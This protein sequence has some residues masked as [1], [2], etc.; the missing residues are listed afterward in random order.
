MLHDT[1]LILKVANKKDF[2]SPL[3][4]LF[5]LVILSAVLSPQPLLLILLTIL[6]F[7]AE[8]VTRI[9][10]FYKVNIVELTLIL[11]PD[12]RMSLESDRKDI[13]G[14]FLEGQQWCTHQ[15]AVL[16]MS[17]GATVR[18]LVI[19]S[20]QQQT[21]DD[22]RRLNMWLRQDLFG[23]VKNKKISAI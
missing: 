18:N 6:F 8:G 19:L 22:F 11:Y 2:V 21:T 3:R 23:R 17:K 10:G 16:R 4:L 5:L 12:G 1:P 20:A 15:L 9:L 14:G 13:I 7:G